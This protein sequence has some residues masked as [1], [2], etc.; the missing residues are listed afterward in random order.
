MK[1][2]IFIG[3]GFSLKFSPDKVFL[4]FSDITRLIPGL[5]TK[6]PEDCSSSGM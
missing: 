1:C 3:T 2:G 5:F 4:Y 6:I